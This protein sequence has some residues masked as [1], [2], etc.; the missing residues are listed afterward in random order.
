MVSRAHE[1]SLSPEATIVRSPRIHRTDSARMSKVPPST[2]TVV[3]FVSISRSLDY[4]QGDSKMVEPCLPN[5]DA[6]VCPKCA[7]CC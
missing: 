1:T 7:R 2:F 5:A 6:W 4:P 3:F